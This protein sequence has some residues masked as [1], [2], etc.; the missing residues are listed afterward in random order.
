MLIH[1]FI[2][3]RA[4]VSAGKKVEGTSSMKLGN[5]SRRGSVGPNGSTRHSSSGTQRP[6]TAGRIRTEAAAARGTGTNLIYMKTI[7]KKE[8]RRMFNAVCLSV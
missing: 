8:L 5:F 2:V 7:L 4:K 6:S 3:K 1:N